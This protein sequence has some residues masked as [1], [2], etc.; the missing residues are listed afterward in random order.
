M[1]STHGQPEASAPLAR[2][3]KVAHH[4]SNTVPD[5][6]DRS[7]KHPHH[8]IHLCLGFLS[9][10][11]PGAIAEDEPANQVIIKLLIYGGEWSLIVCVA[12]RLQ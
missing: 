9:P 5:A 7:G 8:P 10:P 2:L 1:S 6:L 11:H 4:P 3:E 12:H